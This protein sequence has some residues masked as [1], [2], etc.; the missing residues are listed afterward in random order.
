M[1]KISILLVSIILFLFSN[2]VLSQTKRYVKAVATG[3]GDGSS[4]A[5]AS[6]NLQA[7]IDASAPADQVW[8]AKGTFKPTKTVG[9]TAGH[10]AL[11]DPR[12]KSFDLS[13]GVKLY[14]GFNGN[15]ATMGQRNPMNKTIL[16]GDFLGNDVGFTNNSENAYHVIFSANHNASVTLDG[17]TITGGNTTGQPQAYTNINPWYSEITADGGAFYSYEAGAFIQNCVFINNNSAHYGGAVYTYSLGGDYNNCL[18][19][20]NHGLDGA[21]TYT[22]NFSNTLYSHFVNCTMFGNSSNAAICKATLD[23]NT[24]I[25][26]SI[27]W[28]NTTTGLSAGTYYVYNSDVQNAFAS[29]TRAD[30]ASTVDANPFFTNAADVDGADNILGTADDGLIPQ[31]GPAIGGGTNT[32]VTFTKDFKNGTR[33]VNGNVDMGIYETSLSQAISSLTILELSNHATTE[34]LPGRGY[35]EGKTANF[36]AQTAGNGGVFEWTQNGNVVGT[37]SPNLS[38]TSFHNGDQL[39]LKL[40][41]P[42]NTCGSG[43]V[44]Q[45]NIITLA[46]VSNGIPVIPSNIT[47]P[48]NACPYFN[49]TPVAYKVNK[50]PGAAVY[51]WYVGSGAAG[52]N[53]VSHPNGGGVNDTIVMVT[54]DASWD[55]ATGV[56]YLYVSAE[57]WCGV[58]S[59]KKIQIKQNIPVTPAAITGPADAC[60]YMPSV[61]NPSGLPATYFI[62]KV[63]DAS[64]YTWTIP[65]NAI[66]T[67]PNGA[68]VNDTVVIVT[69]NSSYVTGA[70]TVQAVNFCGAKS[71]RSMTVTKRASGTPGM[72]TGP[73]TVCAYMQS[74]SNP[75]GTI[76]EYTIRKVLYATSYTWTAPASAAVTHPNGAGVN[77]TIIRVIFNNSY[78]GGT[79]TVKS[80]TNCNTSAI[81]SLSL[82]YKLPNTPY[83]VYATS[84]TDCPQR[85]VTFSVSAWPQ[86]SNGITWTIPASGTVISYGTYSVEVEFDGTTSPSDTVSVV[87]FNDCGIS[88]SPRKIRVPLFTSTCRFAGKGND[89][90]NTNAIAKNKPAGLNTNTEFDVTAFPNPGHQ[91]FTIQ[92]TGIDFSTPASL[93]VTDATGRQMES[94]QHIQNTI[95]VGN[96]WKPGM[97]FITVIQGNKR[98]MIRLVKL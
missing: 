32:Q 48:T 38:I 39:R 23:D 36:G 52:V 20:N 75:S 96:N 78:N 44:V 47:G 25:Y 77:D 24:Y 91:Q 53:I 65:A 83:A 4:W 74:P 35:C 40:T 55:P 64:S 70:I 88:L 42:P 27:I 86:Y 89:E 94:M 49:G 58:S 45:S 1:K 54:F 17:L 8:I 41:N 26:N 71:P 22:Q 46:N 28:G 6:S 60:P 90:N 80:N 95:T 92:L 57:N 51:H 68:G 9:Y 13:N 31:C 29:G 37:N 16:S 81:R 82:Y 72:I 63:T 15:E 79:I 69:F 59:A 11:A 19:L 10:V 85:R 61:A 30:A 5:N 76:A 3:T 73:T 7:M 97:Y 33:I 43:G 34:N 56:R 2:I 14:G 50:A 62:R 18:F 66:A 21:A 12:F 67:H 87:G 84:P 93:Q 98:K